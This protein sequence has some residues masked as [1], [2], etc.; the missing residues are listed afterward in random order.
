MSQGKAKIVEFRGEKITLAELSKR[1]GIGVATLRTR[2]VTCGKSVE[3]A[4]T[5]PVRK[6]SRF[7]GRHPVNVPRPVPK[8][9]RHPSGRAYSRW[10]MLGKVN[11]RYFGKHGTTEANTAYRRFAQDWTAGKYDAATESGMKSAGGISVA[12]LAEKWLSH[13]R[14]YYTKDG[15]PTSEVRTCTAAARLLIESGENRLAVDFDPAALRTCRQLFIDRGGV[16]ASVNAY[17]GRIVRMF[18]W[19]AGQSLVPPTVHGALKLVEKLKAGRSAA[20]DRAKK[21]PATD[22]QIEATLPHLAPTD[23]KRRAKLVTMI[24]LQRLTGMRPGE[25]CALE[26]GDLERT[27]DVWIY[28]VGKANKNRH[29]GKAQT[30]YLGPKA[31]SLLAPYLE[32]NPAGPIFGEGP[33]DYSQA[34][35][36]A[37]VKA[38]CRWTPHQLRHALATEVA[39]KFRSLDYAAAAIGDT[40][41]VAEAFY[42]HMDP[43]MRA[44]IEIARAMG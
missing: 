9:K 19:G 22:A 14:D 40:R 31:V 12:A 28:R 6:K 20:P 43:Q 8:F 38:K 23:A 11:E 39:E 33:E 17:V 42:V 3:E 36:R 27:T 5:V 10:K 37:S 4:A 2:I 34:I 26:A 1:T 18:A 44:K 29:R 32:G 7:G 25:V 35:I 41:A 30:Y 15:K 16:R 13:V 24:R 21:R